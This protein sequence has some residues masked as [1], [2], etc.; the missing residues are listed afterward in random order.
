[1]NDDLRRAALASTDPKW[2]SQLIGA[3]REP[4][5]ADQI[6]ENDQ[7]VGAGGE[8]VVEGCQPA[9]LNSRVVE[10]VEGR[11][12]SGE[13]YAPDDLPSER[14]EPEA[15]RGG[16]A[17]TPPPP[18]G[19]SRRRARSSADILQAARAYLLEGNYR[20]SMSEICQRAGYSL[21]TGFQHFGTL[22]NLLLTV[23]DMNGMAETIAVVAVSGTP[24]DIARRLVRGR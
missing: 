14:P 19:R 12:Q 24:L 2:A 21:R 18:D 8:T 23:L 22:E 17:D 9:P 16:A 11:E 20:P 7:A 5:P 6:L 15:S 10:G 13:G 1:M 4:I 3:S